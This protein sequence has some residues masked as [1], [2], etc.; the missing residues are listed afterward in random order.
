M[1][2]FSIIIP[3]YNVEEYLEQCLESV[4][5][6]TYHDYEVIIVNDGTKDKSM[7]IAKKYP[8]KI[9]NQKNQGLSVA[10]NTG[11]KHATGDYILF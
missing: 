11:V 6:Q 9:I 2:K 10:R 7:K 5:K 3:V 1:P 4:K 8:Y